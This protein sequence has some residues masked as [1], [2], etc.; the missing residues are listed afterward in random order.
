DLTSVETVGIHGQAHRAAGAPPLEP[1]VDEHAIESLAL[2]RLPDALRAGHDE[3]RDVRRHPLATHDLRRLA[4]PG[5]P[6]AGARADQRDVDLYP[7]DRLAAP[8]AP[9]LDP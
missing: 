1:G 3:R 7:L 4:Q 8:E 6:R 5:E 2:G 9:A